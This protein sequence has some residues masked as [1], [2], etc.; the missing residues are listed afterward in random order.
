MTTK[1]FLLANT[2]GTGEMAQWVRPQLF[3][4]KTQVHFPAPMCSSSKL[5]VTQA[6]GDTDSY[7]TALRGTY[8]H[9]DT[10]LCSSFKIKHFSC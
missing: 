9:T 5:L 3:L 7:G 6:P 4:R 8:P 10:H 2:D 1:I